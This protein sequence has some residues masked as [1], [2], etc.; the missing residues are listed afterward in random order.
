MAGDRDYSPVATFGP[1]YPRPAL[2]QGIQGYCVIQ[3]TVTS[4]GTVQDPSVMEDQCTNS[5]FIAPSI[6]A[7]LKFEFRP[8]I[9]DSVAVDVPGVQ[10]KFTYQ[11][12]DDLP[13]D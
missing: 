3:Y 7:T 13:D 9:I 4:L 6:E 2:T 10:N 5:L 12:S 8:R 11:I 1:I